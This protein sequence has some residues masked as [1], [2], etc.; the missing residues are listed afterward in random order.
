MKTAIY[1]GSFDP[2]TNGHLDVINRGR[3]IFDK[4]VV[5]VARNVGKDPLFTPDERVEMIQANVK[6]RPDIEVI[7]F[8]GLIVDLAEKLN[9]VALIRGMRAVSD[10]EH[11]FQMAQMNRHLD[12]RIETIFLM[13]NERY[14]FTSS[15][16]VKQVFRFTDREKHLIPANVHAALSEKFGHTKVE[17][18]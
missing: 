2:I 3:H 13:P 6:D 18:F 14:F 12:E 4:V 5:A 10:F 16:L 9:A 8:D 15:N 1:P 17:D 11:E 7:A